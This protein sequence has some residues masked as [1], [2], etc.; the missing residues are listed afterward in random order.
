MT[1]KAENLQITGSFKARGATNAIGRMSE[2]SWRR[3]GGRQRRQ[4]RAGRGVRG[5][6]G[7]RT[8]AARDA[9]ARSLAKVAAVRQ[10]GGEVGFVDGGYDEAGG[11]GGAAGARRGHARRARL[12]P[13]RGRGGPGHGGPRDRRAGAGHEP[14]R[15]AAGRR[16]PGGRDRPGASALPARA[17]GSWA[18]RRRAARPTSTRWR[19]TGPIGARSANTICDGI[20]VKRPG[21]YTLRSWSATWTRS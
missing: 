1:L 10:Y 5:A 12:R 20:A 18:C 21:D 16:R 13:A 11:G 19:R 17:P 2:R 4:P 8:G 14:R 3:R 7:R 15:G 6:R 9:G